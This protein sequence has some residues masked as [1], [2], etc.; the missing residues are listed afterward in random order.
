MLKYVEIIERV[1]KNNQ[2]FKVAN[3]TLVSGKGEEKVHTNASA[4]GDKVDNIKDFKKGDFVKLTGQMK[5]TKGENGKEFSN[6]RIISAKLLK[7]KEQMKDQTKDNE[8][9]KDEIAELK[10]QIEERKLDHHYAD[11]FEQATQITQDNKD[12]ENRLSILEGV[13]NNKMVNK[14]ADKGY[15]HKNVQDTTKESVLKAIKK[16]QDKDKLKK[17]KKLQ[18]KQKDKDIRCGLRAAPLFFYFK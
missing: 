4:Y 18:R 3:L 10:S 11:S 16:Y 8:K 12:M 7:S 17:G 5:I 2:K 6:F 13:F 14:I 15:N 1:N 9:L